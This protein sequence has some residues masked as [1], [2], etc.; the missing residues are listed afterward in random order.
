MKLQHLLYGILF[1]V[2]AFSCSDDDE[3]MF[4]CEITD[5]SKNGGTVSHTE[6]ANEYTNGSKGTVK[7]NDRESN[8]MFAVGEYIQKAS[9]D[10]YQADIEVF[11]NATGYYSG[12]YTITF[13][14][15]E[16]F[17]EGKTYTATIWKGGTTTRQA[18]KVT[19]TKLDLDN[20]LLSITF[21]GKIHHG[22]FYPY[23]SK[24]SIFDKYE[25]VEQGYF[26]DM[27]FTFDAF[28]SQYE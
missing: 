18:G 9:D 24:V 28:R 19:I 10:T 22:T 3:P 25:V 12:E 2:I 15:N 8:C 6:E 13:S 11:K 27:V 21:T 23:N 20:N 7:N 26:D 17:Q 5:G 14:S 16:V 1:S 4:R